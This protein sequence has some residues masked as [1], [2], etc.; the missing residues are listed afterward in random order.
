MAENY[1]SGYAK[2]TDGSARQVLELGKKVHYFNPSDTPIFTLLGRLGTRSTPVPKFEWMEDEHFIKRSVQVVGALNKIGGNSIGDGKTNG[3]GSQ[4]A[5]GDNQYQ[6]VITFPRQAQMELFEKGGIYKVTS[7]HAGGKVSNESAV[8]GAYVFCADIGVGCASGAKSTSVAFEP[9]VVDGT[10]V[11]LVNET[12]AV[13]ASTADS[14]VWKFEYHGT[15]GNTAGSGT[16]KGY[17]YNSADNADDYVAHAWTMHGPSLGYNEGAGVSAMSTKK[18]RRLANYTQIFREPFSLTR[19]MRVSKQYGEQEYARLQARK[20]TK[21]KGDLEW[22]LLMQGDADADA[23]AMN[24]K[25]TFMGFGIGASAGEGAIISND[26]RSNTDFQCV[27][28]GSASDLDNLDEVTA[29]I[30]QDTI[31]GSMSKVAF[32]SNRW[33]KKLVVAVRKSS[34]ASINAEM[35]SGV[36]AGLRVTKH[37]GPVGELQFIPHPLL[38]GA[39]EDYA[40]VVDPANVEMRPL[41]QSDMQL[42]DD[43]VK[44]GTDGTVSE[45]LYEGAPEIRNEQTHAILKVSDS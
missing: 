33:L 38:N 10:K 34:G 19:T 13:F 44:D 39:Y 31:S 28:D 32:C 4:A 29:N 37:H 25:R 9:V 35:G 16:Q 23:S 27:M 17:E 6:G 2:F 45:W 40:L 18:V 20:L 24:P 43:I 7:N 26:G 1:G 5:E 8:S 42:R 36:T 21:I 22:A 11:T 30:F 3:D 41:A 14:T 12:A 15:A